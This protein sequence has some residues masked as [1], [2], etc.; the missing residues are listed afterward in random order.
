MFSG[1]RPLSKGRGMK[2]YFSRNVFLE[3]CF[4]A[5]LQGTQNLFGTGIPRNLQEPLEKLRMLRLLQETFASQKIE[6]FHF[7]SFPQAKLSTRE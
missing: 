7:C 1:H 5:I 4:R 3:I 2:L 6:S